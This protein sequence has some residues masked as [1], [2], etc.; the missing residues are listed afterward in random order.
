MTP[1]FNLISNL[2]YSANGSVVDTLICDGNIV[3]KNRQVD[4]EEEII[5]K[6]NEIA[7]NLVVRKNNL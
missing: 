2:V 5:S 1:N 7:Q 6:A 3:M 4:G